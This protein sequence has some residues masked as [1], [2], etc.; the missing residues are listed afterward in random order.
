MPTIA[1]VDGVKIQ[2]FYNDHAPAHF[3]ATLAGEEALI[4]IAHLDVIRGALPTSRLRRVLAWA[5]ENQDAL[6]LNWIRC[7]EDQA[8]ERI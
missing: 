1:V 7:Q 4:A 8:P 3:H 2:M 5:R 6:A